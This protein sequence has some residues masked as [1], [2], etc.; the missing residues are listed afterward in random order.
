MMHDYM[1]LCVCT[2]SV[3]SDSLQLHGLQPAR[4]LSPW[5][6]Q[7]KNTGVGCHFLF[8]GIFPA[9][10]SNPSITCVSYIGRWILYHCT[11]WEAPHIALM[12]RQKLLQLSWEV[13]INLLYSPDSA[14]LYFHLFRTLQN[15]LNGKN[16]SSL[17]EYK[18]HLEQFFAQKDKKFGEARIMTLPENGRRQWNKTVT[19]LFNKT[20][21]ENEKCL[22]FLLKIK[23]TFWSTQCQ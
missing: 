17:E 19:M 14:P 7:G 11:T 2:W 9:Q 23:G 12:T 8:Q 6:F 20:L 4:L 18:R 5:N 13:L 22:L 3:M 16:C 1:F 15:S 10:R 21:G